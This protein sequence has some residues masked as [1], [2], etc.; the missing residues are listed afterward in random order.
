M[1]LVPTR[2]NQAFGAGY[3]QA[4]EAGGMVINH[5]VRRLREVEAQRDALVTA[6]ETA[7]ARFNLMAG[8][9]L[10][11]GADPKVGYRECMDVLRAVVGNAVKP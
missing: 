3:R 8:V 4:S 9:G 2:E 10:V 5:L 11:N 6:L 7:A 1:S